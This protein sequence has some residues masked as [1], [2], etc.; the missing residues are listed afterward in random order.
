MDIER[1]VI[2]A[3]LRNN[4]GMGTD[5]VTLKGNSVL[6]LRNNSVKALHSNYIKALM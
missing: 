1:C 4:N 3:A 2:E 6:L 5:S